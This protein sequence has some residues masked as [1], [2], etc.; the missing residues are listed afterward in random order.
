[1]CVHIRTYSTAQ[2]KSI[3]THIWV[4]ERESERKKEPKPTKLNV[5]ECLKEK[6]CGKYAEN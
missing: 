5:S 3:N 1:M 4:K 6:K 2:V